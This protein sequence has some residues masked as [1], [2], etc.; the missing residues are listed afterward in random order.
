M[1]TTRRDS[2]IERTV[3]GKDSWLNALGLSDHDWGVGILALHGRICARE[4]RPVTD[5][6]MVMQWVDSSGCEDKLTVRR[7]YDP[8]SGSG[9][10]APL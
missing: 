8:R 9:G 10:I 7:R 4:E 3:S 6:S 5:V 2:D 1:N